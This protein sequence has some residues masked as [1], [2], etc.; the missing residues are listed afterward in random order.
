M[1]T[2][3]TD[4]TDST[5][6]SSRAS[7]D[8]GLAEGR[9]RLLLFVGLGALGVGHLADAALAVWCGVAVV[10]AAFALNTAGKLAHYRGLS[11]PVSHRATLGGSWLLLAATVVGLL[12]DYAY[13][14]YG[15]GDGAFFWSLAVAGVG[16]ALLHLGAQATY[17]PPS[18]E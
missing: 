3:D 8:P 13:A 9:S 10:V 5:E 12:A 4:S 7:I 17:L 16:F 18:G 2:T 6:Y 1:N 15:P 14:R 11:V